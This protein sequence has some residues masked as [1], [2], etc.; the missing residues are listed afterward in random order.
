M[1]EKQKHSTERSAERTYDQVKAIADRIGNK[2]L[3]NQV[4]FSQAHDNLEERGE[5]DMIVDVRNERSVAPGANEYFRMKLYKEDGSTITYK[6]SSMG[7]NTR[8]VSLDIG[9]SMSVSHVKNEYADG[10]G[11][12]T[13]TYVK[14]GEFTSETDNEAKQIPVSEVDAV[15]R[16]M[17]ARALWRMHKA[18]QRDAHRIAAENN[19]IANRSDQ[20]ISDINSMIGSI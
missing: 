13:K 5:L 6:D 19:A 1:S 9:D 8:N 10:D 16:K 17:D 15:S 14:A 3:A 2:A 20:R 7:R 4:E 18:Q 11:V 12:K